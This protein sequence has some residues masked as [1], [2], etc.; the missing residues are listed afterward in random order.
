MSRAAESCARELLETVPTVMRF[1]RD[2]VRR[3]H[4]TGLSLPQYRTLIFLHRVK[5]ASLSAVAGHLGLSLPAMSRLIN[6][7]VAGGLVGRRTVSSN[8][9]QIALTLTTRGQATLE[10]VR[11]AIRRRLA[12][13]LKSLPAS[14]QKAIQRALRVLRG[15]FGREQ[16]AGGKTGRNEP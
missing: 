6:G 10:T 1:I 9:R 2:Q 13:A 5:D 15:A 14:E 7:L 4:A 11:D 12:G 16:E 8:R 3:R